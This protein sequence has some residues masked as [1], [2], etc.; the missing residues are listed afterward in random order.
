VVTSKRQKALSRT[1]RL[2]KSE[3][4]SNSVTADLVGVARIKAR[5][6]TDRAVAAAAAVVPVAGGPR[7]VVVL[8]TYLVRGL[9]LVVVVLLLATSARCNRIRSLARPAL[10]VA[11]LG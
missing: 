4:F 10:D 8:S 11:D 5:M 7:V 1:D 6:A 2:V 3:R 9:D